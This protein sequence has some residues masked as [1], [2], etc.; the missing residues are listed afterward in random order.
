[1]IAR[2]RCLLMIVGVAAALVVAGCGGGN[3]GGMD[4]PTMP[5]G[6]G[7]PMTGDGDPMTSA[8][9]LTPEEA[10]ASVVETAT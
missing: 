3:G 7:D 2:S 9:S 10:K 5:T 6:D 1:M 4:G 8:K